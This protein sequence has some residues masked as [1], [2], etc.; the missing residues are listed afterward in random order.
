MIVV[1]FQETDINSITIVSIGHRFT[2]PTLS[3]HF[4]TDKWINGCTYETFVIL[5]LKILYTQEANRMKEITVAYNCSL[6]QTHAFLFIQ[7]D[8]QTGQIRENLNAPPPLLKLGHKIQEYFFDHFTIR[9]KKIW[10]VWKICVT[11][12]IIDRKM[13]NAVEIQLGRRKMLS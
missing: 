6:Y 10:T 1:F 9:F 11:L 2:F 8:R 5:Y 12:Y 3:Q 4:Q 13:T 7:M